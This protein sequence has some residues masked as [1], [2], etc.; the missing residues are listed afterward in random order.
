MLKYHA[1]A[2]M[3]GFILDLLFGDPKWMYH[4]VIF[5]GTQKTA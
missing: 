4:P 1:V 2:L 3:A 5:I